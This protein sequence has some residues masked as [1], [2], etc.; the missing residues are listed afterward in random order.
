ALEEFGQP[1]AVPQLFGL[2]GLSNAFV[3]PLRAAPTREL[4]DERMRQ[5]ML[6]DPSQLGCH[7]GHALHRN[8]KLAVIYGSAPR[9]GLGHI[10][11]ALF[12]IEDDRNAAARSDSQLANQILVLGLERIKQLP[13]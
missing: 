11:E 8:T 6:Q 4:V 2:D 3:Q 1:S 7:G 5:L 9:R 13:T 12:G 10:E